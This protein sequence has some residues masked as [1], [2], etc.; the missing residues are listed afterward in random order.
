MA[1]IL[2]IT[3][4]T[5]GNVNDE[6]AGTLLLTTILRH[7]GLDAGIMPFAQFGDPAAFS[8][9]LRS[10]TEAVL[11]S[12]ARIVSF[13][14]RCD[15]YHISLAL[16]EQIK[17]C[18]DKY[19]VFGGPQADI[20]AVDTLLE[21]P[22]VDYI[23][24]GEGELTVVPFFSSLLKGQPDLS[25]PGLVYRSNGQVVQNPRP[26][27]IEDLDSLPDVDYS[28]FGQMDLSSNAK[29]FL[30]DVGRGCPFGCTYCSTKT[31]W[32]RKYRLKSPQRIFHEVKRLH[33]LYGI[34]F[35]AFSHD[36]FTMNRQQVIETCRLL[37][38]LAFPVSWTCSARIDCL[39][40]ELIDIM[41]E[42]GLTRIFIGL[43]TGSARMQK[44]INKN[45]KLDRALELLRYLEHK[46]LR[47]VISFIYGFPE[48][49]E[50]D[51]SQTLSLIADILKIRRVQLSLHLCAFL[52]GTELEQRYLSELTPTAHYSNITGAIAL[53]ECAEL[54]RQHPRIFSY[55]KEYNTPLRTKLM[56]LPVF[57]R[58]WQTMQPVYQYFSEKYP[59]GRLYDM[60][61]DFV[62]ANQETLNRFAC[63]E[64]GTAATHIITDD[65][66]ARL[67]PNDEFADLIADLYRFTALKSA[68]QLTEGHPITDVFCFSPSDLEHGMRL[69]DLPRR[70]TVV[71]FTRN[72]NQRI[73]LRIR[74]Y[75]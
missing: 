23:C 62:R 67:F 15:T 29:P 31:F 16:A 74:N 42:A 75:R 24:C 45:L 33:D 17:L 63:L 19:I 53:E 26:A 12:N 28:M 65:R 66:F 51:I 68:D 38:T 7:S 9:F 70:I 41:T 18:S 40:R 54:I 48:E 39:D 69:Q 11:R 58:V 8:V 56:Y 72:Q 49:T 52:P 60:Y 44:L 3:P 30:I 57:V 4:N 35:F 71:T 10:A 25:V 36:M 50:D 46:G 6:S 1:D 59:S 20:S 22:Y 34:T 73:H 47:V 64:F 55:F 13:Y 61:E 21:I 14:S 5:S 32:G 27:L 37:R 2:F 43:E